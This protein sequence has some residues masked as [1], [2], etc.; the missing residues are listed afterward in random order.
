[1]KKINL[2]KTRWKYKKSDTGFCYWRNINNEIL[3]MLKSLCKNWENEEKEYC[4]S[5]L[6]DA[7][8]NLFKIEFDDIPL[9]PDEEDKCWIGILHF[10]TIEEANKIVKEF[11]T[12]I[13]TQ[14]KK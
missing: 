13:N 11:I 5:I 3:I 8:I 10:D 14:Y 9:T 6:T 12:T 2:R 7:D 4:V 1:M